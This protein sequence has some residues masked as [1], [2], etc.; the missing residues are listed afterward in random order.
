MVAFDGGLVEVRWHGRG[1]QGAVT[2]AEI[3]AHAAIN[4]GKYAQASPS[5]GPERRGAPV[6][7]YNRIS[8][9]PILL[10]CE[11]Y[12]P[13]IVVVIDTSLIKTVNVMQGLRPG[14][15]LILNT[16]KSP[17]EVKSML[18]DASTPEQ[19]RHLV[20]PDIRLVTVNALRIALET[21]GI[22]I[23]N[24]SM[25]GAFV[26]ATNIVG[27]E[28]VV[29]CVKERFGKKAGEMNANAVLRAYEETRVEGE[30]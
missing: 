1:G 6:L 21:I 8:D 20:K 24:T 30:E 9:Q 13:D 2:A 25:L 22:P 17:D 28:H 3:L 26:K 10:R 27:L 14:G 23:V 16:S 15:L 19:V 12:E 29:E 5:F 18:L 4:E 11:V 7:A